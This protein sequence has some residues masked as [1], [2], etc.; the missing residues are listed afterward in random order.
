MNDALFLGLVQNAALLLTVAFIFDMAANRWR[1][2]QSLFQQVLLGLGIGTIGITVM[3]TPWTFM[4]G[5]VFDLRSVLI[6]ISGLFFGPF[7]AAVAMMI[8][9]TLRF[10]QGGTGTWTG[11]AVIITSGVIGIAWRHFRGQSLT[12]IS[13]RELYLFGIVIHSAMLGLMLT[14]PWET[15]LQVLSNIFLPVILIYPIVTTLLGVLMVN[16]L[17]RERA[18]D[19][20]RESEER[21]RTLT[22]S[23]PEAIFVQSNGNYVYLN[24]A[25][26]NLLGASHPDELLG[27]KSIERVA[28]EYRDAV[29][30]SISFQRETGKSVPPMEQEYL[31]M[32]GSR[33][34]VETTAIGIQF[35]G[36]N[37]NLVF[38]RDITARKYTE[39][40]LRKSEQRFRQLSEM[41]PQTIFEI[42]ATGN[43][44]FVN[45]AAL[46][47][48]GYMEEE[49]NAGMNILALLPEE[50]HEKAIKNMAMVESEGMG[51]GNEY[52]LRKKNGELLNV[53]LYSNVIHGNSGKVE[54]FR[55]IIIDITERKQA[56]DALREREEKYWNLFNNAEVGIFRTRLDGSEV[57]DANDKYLSMLGMTR[58]EFI[59][60]PSEIV[61][62]DPKE[63]EEMVKKL[64]VQGYVN[65]LEF[66]LRNKAGEVRNCITSLK[67]YQETGILEGSII[68]ITERKRAEE[69]QIEQLK[70]LQ[71]LIDTIPIPVFFKDTKGVYLGCNEA[72]EPFFGPR[73]QLLGKT[74][75]DVA[76]KDIADIY[77]RA[78]LELFNKPGV[79]IYETLAADRLG[80]KHNVIFN[81]A[82]YQDKNGKVSRVNRLVRFCSK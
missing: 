57:L 62:D 66:R 69:V 7:S 47:L 67:L 65:E 8:T 37:A 30:N 13:W 41:M 2:G 58:E 28:P 32:D 40:S 18:D 48:F 22:E 6:G 50:E 78:D 81:K 53:L 10:Y 35:E 43:I 46:N 15:A 64:K 42:D 12:D 44:L 51:N 56:A 24:P 20:L 33:V 16:R 73:D 79:Q 52:M 70:F 80:A 31:R 17:E 59:G 55:G 71:V 61:W 38:V 29:Y 5:V 3:M 34:S 68:D 49:V 23:G 36:K 82:T 75:Y 74:V 77:Y 11:V 21:F 9:A 27:Q 60:K 63:R 4:P 1:T 76:P 25:M 26:L 19:A 72:C 14:L 39:N 45:E 54:G